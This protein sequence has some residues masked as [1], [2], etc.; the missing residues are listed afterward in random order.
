MLPKMRGDEL[1]TGEA[2]V[3][4]VRVIGSNFNLS[5][6]FSS[7]NLS[8]EFSSF[9]LACEFSSFNLSCEF[10]SNAFSDHMRHI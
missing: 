3:E 7:F 10:S 9:N 5:C 2:W 1:T 6:Q 8:C 4:S